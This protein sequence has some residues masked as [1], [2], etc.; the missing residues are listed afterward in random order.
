MGLSWRRCIIDPVA[1]EQLLDVWRRAEAHLD[2]ARRSLTNPDDEALGLFEEFRDHNELD[3]ALDQLADVAHVQRAPRI[4]W[5]ELRAAAA[6]MSLDGGNP[7]Y[8][9]TVRRISEHLARA[10]DWEA[11]RRLINEWDPVGVYDAKTD[12]PPDEY[13]CL[14]APVMNLLSQGAD[15]AEVARFLEHELSAHFGLD[16]RPCHPAEF[17]VRLVRWFQAETSGAGKGD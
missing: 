6:V 10:G 14:Y 4:V 13:D 1:D 17:A 5:Q 16:P 8:G 3:L 11:L 9:A 15:A 2:Q 12:F 7:E